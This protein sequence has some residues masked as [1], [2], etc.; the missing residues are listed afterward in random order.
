MADVHCAGSCVTFSAL[1]FPQDTAQKLAHAESQAEASTAALEVER[2]RADALERATR[3]LEATAREAE[4][5]LAATV[6]E[7]AGTADVADGDGVPQGVE[8]RDLAVKRYFEREVLRVLLAGDPAEKVL[9]LAREVCGLKVVESQLLGSL[10]AAR[11]RADA[12]HV[13]A[14]ALAE[15]LAAAHARLEELRPAVG[16]AERAGSGRG[17]AGSAAMAAQL[18]AKA[19]EVFRAREEALTTAQRLQA[20]EA[21]LQESERERARL[22][23]L[24]V[25]AS[26]VAQGTVNRAREELAAQHAAHVAALE[27]EAEALRRRLAEAAREARAGAAAAAS[28]SEEERAAAVAAATAGTAPA[29]EVARARAEAEVAAE[30]ERAAREEAEAL[31]RDLQALQRKCLEL[32]DERETHGRALAELERTLGAIERAGAGAG[33]PLVHGDGGRRAATPG[34]V[35]G[36]GGETATVGEL[37]RQLVQAR[38]GEADAQRRLR[39]A[40]RSELELREQL[41]R[42]DARIAQLKAELGGPSAGGAGRRDGASGSAPGTPARGTPPAR[43]RRL[44]SADE[45]AEEGPGAA[46][47]A[48]AAQVAQL[49]A[50]V[51]RKA[52]QVEHLEVSLAQAVAAQGD[53]EAEAARLRAKETEVHEAMGAAQARPTRECITSSL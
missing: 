52:A 21:R 28:R 39:V 20:A 26:A 8:A 42:R 38:L 27:G 5:R 13:R 46:S 37:S 23:A 12:A 9:S 2:D 50:E 1:A 48:A 17:A 51:A 3:V 29:E 16:A 34:R 6:L 45:G 35:R 11:K 24:A 49:R 40:A 44:F 10:R 22:E 32:R 4:A 43:Q 18:G 31:L 47:G 25:R 41:R 53:R 15:A 7:H 33:A 14:G 30:G 19:Q 36:R